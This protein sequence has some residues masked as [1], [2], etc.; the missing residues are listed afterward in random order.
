MNKYQ[1]EVNIKNIK[2]GYWSFFGKNKN[3]YILLRC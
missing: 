3:V 1:N 2:Y